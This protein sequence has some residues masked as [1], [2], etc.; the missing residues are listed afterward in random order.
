MSTLDTANL[1]EN[2]SFEQREDGLKLIKLLAP[3][4]GNK[5]LD[6][7][8]GTGYLSKVLADLVG[9]EGQVVA[10]DPDTERLKVAKDK[11]TASNLQYLEGS[12]DNIPG[13]EYDIVFSNYVLQ[14]I[15][16]KGILFKDIAQSLKKGGKF[17]FVTPSY[18]NDD[19]LTPA[20]MCS[21]EYR[22]AIAS[23]LHMLNMDEYKPFF[24]SSNF[25]I[26][27][28]EEH[29]REWKF[30]GVKDLVSFCSVTLTH[31]RF[32][33]THFDIEAMRKHHG[34]D[35]IFFNPQILRAI[36]RKM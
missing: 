12:S 7:G 14:W 10:I 18:Q 32:D 15:K 35:E 1:Y 34:N 22:N 29:V 28:S 2:N 24:S 3:E 6:L 11:Y 9:P 19:F 20:E 13:G 16:Y 30:N 26:I 33:E 27:Y 25:E 21:P 5:V 8:C 4:K 36:L 31:G 23:S 17:A